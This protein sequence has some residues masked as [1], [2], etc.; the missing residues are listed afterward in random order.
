MRALPIVRTFILG[1]FAQASFALNSAHAI[2]WPSLSD[3]HR[4]SIAEQIFQNE[5]AGNRDSLVFWSDR[6]EFPSL[7]IGHFIWFPSDIDMPFVESFPALIEY[8]VDQNI[9]VP[10]MLRSKHAPWSNREAF[11]A[12]KSTGEL[13]AIEAFLWQSRVAQYGYI[14][15]QARAHLSEFSDDHSR[16][17][18]SRM[19]THPGG[20]YVLVD[21]LNFKGTGL[22]PKERYQKQG[23]GLYQVLEGMAKDTGDPIRDFRDSAQRVLKRR[24]EL[25]PSH[26]NEESWL[27]GWYQRLNTYIEFSE[28]ADK[29]LQTK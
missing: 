25:A 1:L 16:N 20:V 22:N 4:R 9:A 18:I 27:P 12:Q 15:K 17:V 7:G 23:W 21:Y 11:Y 19:L 24:T 6:E 26:R 10:A 5:C 14:E 13:D 3:A 29:A 28:S 2:E 8:L